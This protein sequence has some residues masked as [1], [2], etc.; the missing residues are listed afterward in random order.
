M[1]TLMP[2]TE[3]AWKEAAINFP[4]LASLWCKVL[5]MLITVQNWTWPRQGPIFHVQRPDVYNLFLFHNSQIIKQPWLL[6]TWLQGF[7]NR[8]DSPLFL[9]KKRDKKCRASHYFQQE[10]HKPRNQNA[11]AFGSTCQII[12]QYYSKDRERWKSM[13]L[14]E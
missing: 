1:P 6:I 5:G 10:L 9:I 7:S 13:R 8:F 12:L 2:L 4:W 11:K 3:L 14:L